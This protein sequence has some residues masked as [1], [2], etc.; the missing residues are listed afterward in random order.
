MEAIIFIGIQATGK[1]TFYV[2]NFLKSHIRISLDMLHTRNKENLFLETCLQTQQPFVI[3]NTNPTKADREKY[4]AK[5][6]DAKFR[7]IGYY[8]QSKIDE[9]IA[10]NN[11]RSG[12][13]K[14]PVKGLRG[15]HA[16]L[17]L[18]DFWEGFDEL[19]YVELD[20]GTFNVK[21]WDNEI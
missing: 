19:Y 13:E 7:V 3:D 16:K 21:K 14:I 17:E 4:I 12:T 20:N 15:T 11:L 5:A 9:A 6:K 10:R 18:P 2:Q 1:T 8:F